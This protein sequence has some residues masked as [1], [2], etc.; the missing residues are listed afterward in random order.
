MNRI[1]CAVIPVVLASSLSGCASPILKGDTADVTSTI[2]DVYT[3]QTLEN[4]SRFIDYRYTIPSLVALQ[5]GQVEVDASFNPSITIPFGNQVA[6]TVIGNPGETI[7]APSRAFTL[8]GSIS[9]KANFNISP[10]VDQKSL[11][12]DMAL[13][14]YA[15]GWDPEDSNGESAVNWDPEKSN[16]KLCWKWVHF[17]VANLNGEH[18]LGKHGKHRLSM[19]EDSYQ[20]G[21]LTDLVLALM[22]KAS[23][24]KNGAGA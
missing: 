7:T 4:L 19:T 14:D 3:D 9:R 1:T 17:D 15:V 23:P 13:F 20:R 2:A 11:S 8:G 5:G 22:P 16:G 21:C 12:A 18:D 10:I 6:T 24:Q